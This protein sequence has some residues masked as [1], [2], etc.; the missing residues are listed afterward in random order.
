MKKANLMI[1]AVVLLLVTAVTASAE[2]WQ[3]LPLGIPRD[4]ARAVV[5]T[6]GLP[7]RMDTEDAL[8]AENAQLYVYLS[9]DAGSGKADWVELNV[10]GGE[11]SGMDCTTPDWTA[12]C[13]DILA[14]LNEEGA[15]YELFLSE[16]GPSLFFDGT[17]FGADAALYMQFDP[18]GKLA[19]V[20]INEED[21]AYNVLWTARLAASLGLPDQSEMLIDDGAANMD[22]VTQT[23]MWQRNGCVYLLES[24]LSTLA[25]VL[26]D[27]VTSVYENDLDITILPEMDW[28]Q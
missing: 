9:F 23:L 14:R 22:H 20:H 27:E 25:L 18:E 10:L 11:R 6:L 1:I 2:L 4:E 26:D 3:E 12:A 17:A 16:E 15:A 7:I 21:T 28:K 8:L 5:E 13:E 24:R 19:A